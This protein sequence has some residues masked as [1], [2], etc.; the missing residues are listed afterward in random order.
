MR[1]RFTRDPASDG[2][3]VWSPDG[4][5]VIFNSARRG[6]L[7]I[8]WKSP[9][10]DDQEVALLVNDQDKF[11]NDWSADGRFVLFHV[12]AGDD[13]G[14]WMLPLEGTNPP[15][16]RDPVRVVHSDGYD[17]DAVFSPDGRWLAYASRD[18]AIDEVFLAR[19]PG[20]DGKRQ[21]SSGGGAHPRWRADGRELYYLTPRG[22]VVAVPIAQVGDSLQL[23]SP[24][25]LFDTGR[26]LDQYPAFEVTRDGQRFLA[27]APRAEATTPMLTLIT[28]WAR[29]TAGG[30]R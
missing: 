28:N 16:P 8:Y 10:R 17:W 23:G 13:P 18:S 19:V 15:R 9:E 14:I 3:P 26:T 25:T 12:T 4:R 2:S 7:D 22:E 29:L 20:G 6:R 24:T 5:D 30:A 21:V 1:T 27:L 11:V